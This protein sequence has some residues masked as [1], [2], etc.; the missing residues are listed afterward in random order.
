MLDRSTEDLFAAIHDGRLDA[1]RQRLQSVTPDARDSGG[2]P[3]LVAASRTGRLEVVELLLDAG[4]DVHARVVL[5]TRTE[6]PT[7]MIM[8][9]PIEDDEDEEDEEEEDE[10]KDEETALGAAVRL[11]HTSI[12]RRLLAAGAP[13]RPERWDGSWPLEVAARVGTPQ[14]VKMLL[15][16][17][18]EPDQGFAI[19]PLHHA[20]SRGSIEIAKALL[21]AGAT[22]D[23]G[24]EDGTTP[25][26]YAGGNGHLPMVELLLEAGANINVW[27]EGDNVL[28]CAVRTGDAALVSF[29]RERVDDDVRGSVE[30]GELER[31]QIRIRREA[32]RETEGFIDAAMDGKLRKVQRALASK[33][34]AVDALGSMG[35]TALHYA[36]SYG[37]M[38]VIEALL[39]AGADPNMRSDESGPGRAPGSTPLHLIAGSFFA[40]DRPGVIARLVRAGAQLDVRDDEGSTPLMLSIVCGPGYPDAARAL[41]D[42]GADLDVTDHEGSTA[43]MLALAWHIEPVVELLRKAGASERGVR[44]LQL[45]RAAQEG[46]LARVTALLEAGADVNHCMGSTA[47]S[48]AAS[49]GHT[50]IVRALIAAGADLDKRESENSFNPLLRAAYGGHLEAT[51]AL[52]EAGADLCVSIQHMGTALDYARRGK[53]EGHG[54][55]QP[56]DAVIELLEKAGTPSLLG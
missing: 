22:V 25:L 37:H 41:V 53:A 27:A 16:A 11:G 13:L 38:K 7:L 9:P 42:A 3:A 47:L 18:A 33:S 14:I 15:E 50:E 49:D 46:D 12:V 8:G 19:C 56:W 26:M 51:R 55:E 54:P 17:G 40:K 6:G 29:L 10:S 44:E 5:P 21:A 4:A 30:E 48:G 35:Q 20:A 24:D 39:G 36:A 34:V 31:Q 45:L 23:A 28:S 52:V 1:I 32:D 2:V 43:L